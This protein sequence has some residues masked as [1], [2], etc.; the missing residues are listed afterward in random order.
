MTTE[1]A[2]QASPFCQATQRDGCSWSSSL[3]CNAIVFEGLAQ[4]AEDFS[5]VACS[6]TSNHPAG[7]ATRLGQ[8]SLER[9]PCVGLVT[10]SLPAR[11]EV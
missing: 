10:G 9:R 4:E 5:S 1:R 2:G 8:G 6:A 11:K 3:L 7:G